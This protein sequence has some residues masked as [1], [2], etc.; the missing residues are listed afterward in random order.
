MAARTSTCSANASCSRHEATS[1]DQR[2]S[3]YFSAPRDTDNVRA[4]ASPGLSRPLERADPRG[5]WSNIRR[6]RSG[7]ARASCSCRNS[8]GSTLL[9]AGIG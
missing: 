7:L 8:V 5:A 2:Q 1:Q 6:S 3:L 9:S 4:A